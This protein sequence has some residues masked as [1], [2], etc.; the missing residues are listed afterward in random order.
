VIISVAE[1]V[2]IMM[3]LAASIQRMIESIFILAFTAFITLKTAIT[4]MIRNSDI[5]VKMTLIIQ[6]CIVMYG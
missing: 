2:S 3:I 1:S 6:K 4:E 5:N